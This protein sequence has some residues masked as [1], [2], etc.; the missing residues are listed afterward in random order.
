MAHELARG[1]DA[2]GGSGAAVAALAQGRVARDA[3]GQHAVP[4]LLAEAAYFADEHVAIHRERQRTAQIRFVER[5][6]RDVDTDGAERAF[7]RA[8]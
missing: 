6:A 8:A 4:R 2:L 5:R 3:R 7:G 1:G